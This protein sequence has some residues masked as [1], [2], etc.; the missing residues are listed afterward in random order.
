MSKS[1]AKK[2]DNLIKL[3]N[4]DYKAFLNETTEKELEKVLKHLSNIYYND[5][6]S[7]VTDEIFDVLKDHLKKL[8]PKN[9]FLSEIGAPI[10]SGDEVKLPFPMGS[11]EKIKPDTDELEKYMKKY[12]GKYVISD[13]LDGISGQLYKNDKG[14]IFLY[15]RGDGIKGKDI[16][17]LIKY[18]F[19]KKLLEKLPNNFSVRGELI[20]TKKDYEKVKTRFKNTRNAVGGFVNAKKADKELSELVK[21]VAYS[22]LHP[23]IKYEDQMKELEKYKFDMVKYL[24]KDKLSNE[25]LTEY[26]IKRRNESEYD[27][28]GIVVFD[29]SKVY[30]HEEGLPE[31]GFAFKTLLNDQ[32]AEA[33]VVDVIWS[34]SM[35]GFL[36]PRIEIEPVTIGGVTIKYAT[37]FHAKFVLDNKL[38]PG[39]VVKLVRSGDVIPDIQAVIK[40]ATSGKAKMPTV[41]YKWTNTNVN[42]YIE[43]ETDVVK[44]KLID[45]FFSKLGVK[46]ISLGIITKLVENKYNSVAKII[47]AD[48]K[49][50]AKIEGI[51]EKLLDKVFNN[52]DEAFDKMNLIQFMAASHMFGSGIGERKIKLIIEQYPDILT[53]KL[54]KNEFVD[55]LNEIEGFST[56]TSEKFYENLDDF[57]K[58][59][60]EINKI[61]DISHILIVEKKQKVD[62]S[63]PLN[64]LKIVFTGFRDN[65]LK[66]YI[67]D[68]GGKVSDSVSSNTN[69]VVHADG[70]DSSSKIEKAKKLGIT[71]ITKSNFLKKYKK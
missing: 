51:G 32:I 29:S 41:E 58:F 33:V 45:H 4:Q 3:I 26:L 23:R 1:N 2:I 69:I 18:I 9:K 10:A 6:E 27:I 48:K 8:N 34:A 70:E 22:V 60:A 68:N 67:E 42:I 16:S 55:K 64:G 38:G 63:N 7:L 36:K 35:D 49:K 5:D 65:E 53:W 19:N 20:M 12:K 43:E 24:I 44:S 62:E 15:T 28:D 50:L 46:Y 61:K 11:L 56:I 57:K 40:P 71:V 59:Y 31:Y 21:F 37:A 47:G 30:P 39:A 25:Y 17:H 66:K 13:K 54:K 14:E 52:I